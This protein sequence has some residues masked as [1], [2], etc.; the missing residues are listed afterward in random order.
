MGAT[1]GVFLKVGAFGLLPCRA[2][3][4]G[5]LGGRG[6]RLGMLKRLL[7][8]ADPLQVPEEPLHL[9]PPIVLIRLERHFHRRFAVAA[10]AV[11]DLRQVDNR[12]DEHF[13]VFPAAP[14][15]HVS[16]FSRGGPNRM[17][18]KAG[19]MVVAWERAYSPQRCEN[20]R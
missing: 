20:L 15:G 19:V 12:F 10:P 8:S 2:R 16:D 6:Y 3:A 18:V 14:A 13:N 7:G 4:S 1:E 5:Q 11:L 9:G 17:P